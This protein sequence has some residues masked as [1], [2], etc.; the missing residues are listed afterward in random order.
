MPPTA[1]FVSWG[2]KWGREVLRETLWPG[3]G[4][5]AAT[6][7]VTVGT[8]S[9]IFTEK[10]K[11]TQGMDVISKLFC[12]RNKQLELNTIAP[13]PFINPFAA[14]GVLKTLLCMRFFVS[15]DVKL[16]LIYSYSKSHSNILHKLCSQHQNQR[17]ASLL[18]LSVNFLM[19]RYFEACFMS[20]ICIENVKKKNAALKHNHIS[21][22]Q[23][24][25]ASKPASL[26]S[27]IHTMSEVSH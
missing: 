13:A 11:K 9:F 23:L 17:R 12:Q 2:L 18:M 14:S 15:S 16:P 22:L 27:F 5:A 4:P 8:R 7:E 21:Q 3:M 19:D 1:A 10:K 26:F 20:S 6:F 25:L 24:E